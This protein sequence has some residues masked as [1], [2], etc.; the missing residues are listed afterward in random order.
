MYKEISLG[1]NCEK[2]N[3][4]IYIKLYLNFIFLDNRVQRKIFKI[5]KDLRFRD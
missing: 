4:I 5:L 3:G 1:K 2:L